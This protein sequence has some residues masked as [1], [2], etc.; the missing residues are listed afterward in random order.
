MKGWKLQQVTHDSRKWGQVR[1][2]LMCQNIERLVR[3]TS[4]SCLPGVTRRGSM[5][6]GASKAICVG[7]FFVRVLRAYC[8]RL[9]TSSANDFSN[10]STLAGEESD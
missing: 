10:S 7:W 2:L 9:S 3:K 6:P 1:D 5:S 4:A 8:R